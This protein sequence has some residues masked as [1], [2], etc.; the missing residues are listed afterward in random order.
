MKKMAVKVLV[1]ILALLMLLSMASCVKACVIPPPTKIPV[2]AY[3]TKFTSIGYS[4]VKYVWRDDMEYLLYF[5]LSGTISIYNSVSSTL[6]AT[7]NWVDV[8]WGTYNS[9]TN[10][11]SYTFYEV[12]TP[13]STSPA[14]PG[15]FVGFD[16]PHTT[17]DFL[18]A[19]GIATGGLPLTAMEGHI[20]VVG[21]GAC[22]GQV[23]DVYS[24]NLLAPATDY[25]AGYWLTR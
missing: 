12:W 22:A 25:F 9:V 23:I 7:V 6:I 19:F 21:I 4:S 13:G 15:T 16:H 24:P 3:I 20:I 11:G 10:L 18:V 14:L 17:G 5:T 8:C 1:P 2:T